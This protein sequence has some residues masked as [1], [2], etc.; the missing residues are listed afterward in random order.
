MATYLRFHCP[1]P[2][3]GIFQAAFELVGSGSLTVRD[4]ARL[5]RQ[6]DW[7]TEHLRAP[8]RFVRTTSKGYEHRN[9]IAICWFKDDAK[10][11]LRRAWLMVQILE[12]NGVVVEFVRTQYPGYVTY[13]D[14]QQVAA[15]PFA[16]R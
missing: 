13:E 4:R 5:E 6:L 12:R 15:I 7:F 9:P 14:R 16:D 1:G 2:R 11:C 10:R 3:T 8:R